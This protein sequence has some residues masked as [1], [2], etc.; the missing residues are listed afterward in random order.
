[1]LHVCGNGYGARSPVATPSLLSI[2]PTVGRAV[3]RYSS[4]TVILQ[5]LSAPIPVP[6]IS[7]KY[8]LRFLSAPKPVEY[9][10]YQHLHP[11]NTTRIV[12][13]R[14][15][16]IRTRSHAPLSALTA[17]ISNSYQFH[18]TSPIRLLYL[19]YT[20]AI[21]FGFLYLACHLPAPSPFLYHTNRATISSYTSRM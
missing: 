2:L 1:M 18:E 6:L 9:I 11:S 21:T 7:Y 15:Y 4:D 13:I 16:A 5:L 10:S 14:S 12:P 3:V 20:R 19:S 17:P 8:P